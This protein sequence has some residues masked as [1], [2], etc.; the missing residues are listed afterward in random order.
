MIPMTS[1]MK[2]PI[3]IDWLFE[4]ATPEDPTISYLT[5]IF[6]E[7]TK[8]SVF[9]STNLFDTMYLPVKEVTS[10]GIS[11][12]Y[13]YINVGLTNSQLAKLY[14]TL[15]SGNSLL[16]DT[17]GK[18]DEQQ[19]A[20]IIL[21]FHA[22][23]SENLG[24]YL[25]WIELNGYEYNPLWNVDG[26]EI[27][28]NM[29]NRGVNDVEYGGID[30]NVGAQYSDTK[31]THNIS[32]FN[33]TGTRENYNDTRAGNGAGP[34]ASS[35][36]YVR[37]ITEEGD[38]KGQLEVVA[39]T[40]TGTPESVLYNTNGHKTSTKYTHRTAKNIVSGA[41]AEYAVSASDTAFGTALVGADR[42]YLEKYVRQ[43]NIGV[44]KTTDLIESSRTLLKFSIIQ[45]F[46]SDINEPNLIGLYN[47]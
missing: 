1:K 3:P 23:F 45:E 16:G 27:K 22:I 35:V 44:T 26:T 5:H 41:E 32:A 24:K 14:F 4:T 37:E 6:A 31:T 29:E 17:Y 18:T 38:T 11:D 2:R 13:R 19:V 36:E 7:S 10:S 28:Q 9:G 34:V 8:F 33:N 30:S 15:F 40:L 39:P 42:M 46:F 25:K 21:R 12:T 43:G 47:Y 20:A